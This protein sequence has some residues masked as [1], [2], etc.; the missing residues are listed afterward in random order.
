MHCAEIARQKKH[1]EKN[2]RGF[3]F[4]APAVQKRTQTKR[5]FKRRCFDER[6]WR[7]PSLSPP[8]LSSAYGKRTANVYAGAPLH[9]LATVASLRHLRAAVVLSELCFRAVVF[10]APS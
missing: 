3:F 6:R 9:D 4:H 7:P 1:G 5:W 8:L 2:A 10:L